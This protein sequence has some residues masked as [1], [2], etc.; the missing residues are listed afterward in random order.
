[1]RIN[2]FALTEIRKRSGLS[3]S[4]LARQVDISPGHM[5]DLESGRR[6][7]SPDLIQRL[8]RALKVPLPAILAD[9]NDGAAA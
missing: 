9:P 7:P 1:M 6:Q 2:P 5:H 4:A 8:A 3:G